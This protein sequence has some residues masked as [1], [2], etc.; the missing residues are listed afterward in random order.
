MNKNNSNWSTSTLTDFKSERTRASMGLISIATYNDAIATYIEENYSVFR[1]ELAEDLKQAVKDFDPSKNLDKELITRMEDLYSWCIENGY[2]LSSVLA[3]EIDYYE[4]EFLLREK[5]AK[6][7]EIR[8][9]IIAEIDDLNQ[10]LEGNVTDMGLIEGLEGLLR[11]I[12]NIQ[13]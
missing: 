2:P 8:I 6:Q 3:D 10:Y 5:V 9:D 7:K 4:K 11:K 1:E 13:N 12:R